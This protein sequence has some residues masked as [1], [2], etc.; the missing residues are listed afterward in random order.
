MRMTIVR[1]LIIRVPPAVAR[2]ANN[3]LA[4]RLASHLVK[5]SKA[6][7]KAIFRAARSRPPSCCLKN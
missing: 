1:T 6:C 3:L 7:D 4:S 2:I 5:P